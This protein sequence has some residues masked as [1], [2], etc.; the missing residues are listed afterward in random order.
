VLSDVDQLILDLGQG[1]RRPTGQDLEAIRLHVAQAGFDPLAT[2][3][4]DRRVTGLQ[5]SNGQIIRRGDPIPTA[6][7]HYLRH[8]VRLQEWPAGT[9]KDQYEDSLRNLALRLRVGILVSDKP[10][11]GWHLAIIG[12]IGTMRGPGGR[13]WVVVEYRIGTGHWATGF[14]PREGLHFAL[15]RRRQRWL[16]LPT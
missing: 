14:Q 3:P 7:L 8:V 16:R 1:T 9:T 15:M 4:A 10:P 13:E 11:F 6:E 2:Y 5:R 12:R